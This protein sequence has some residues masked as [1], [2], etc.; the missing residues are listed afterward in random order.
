MT[1]HSCCVR[2]ISGPANSNS[3][4]KARANSPRLHLLKRRFRNFCEWI[5]PSVL[6]VLVPKCPMCIAA[7]I[8]LGTG[9]GVSVTTATYL[10]MALIILCLGSFLFTAIRLCNAR[11]VA[12]HLNH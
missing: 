9:I 7:Y 5:V 12:R 10:R 8:A 6:L 3:K 2:T 1:A 4:M 11:V